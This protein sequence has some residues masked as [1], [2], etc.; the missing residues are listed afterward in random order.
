MARPIHIPYQAV[1]QGDSTRDPLYK[2]ERKTTPTVA[3]KNGHLFECLSCN[4]TGHQKQE[5]KCLVGCSFLALITVLSIPYA[6]GSQCKFCNIDPHLPWAIYNNG[7]CLCGRMAFG[8][9]QAQGTRYNC[10]P[11]ISYSYAF[12]P[13]PMFF[14]TYDFI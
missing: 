13:V 3:D 5:G 6:P 12:A 1:I 14:D 10:Y 11:F 4:I 9:S 2:P 8:P 7:F